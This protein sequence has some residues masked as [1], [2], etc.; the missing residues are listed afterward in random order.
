[1]LTN[2][3]MLGLA[4]QAVMYSLHYSSHCV[5]TSVVRLFSRCGVKMT[6]VHTTGLLWSSWNKVPAYYRTHAYYIIVLPVSPGVFAANGIERQR[7]RG[8]QD[9]G[10]RRQNR[11]IV[12][13]IEY[14][15][16]GL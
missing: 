15:C 16:G 13:L 8:G 2:S 5:Y 6:P 10:G 4:F 7:K 1:M 9:I 11:E 3:L 12:S 14:R